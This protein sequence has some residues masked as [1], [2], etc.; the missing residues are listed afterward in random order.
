MKLIL[1]LVSPLTN[2]TLKT[3]NILSRWGHTLLVLTN[4]EVNKHLDNENQ[5]GFVQFQ[6]SQTLSVYKR[7]LLEHE[8]RKL[9]SVYFP[10]SSFWARCLIRLLVYEGLIRCSVGSTDCPSCV[11]AA[12]LMFGMTFPCLFKVGLMLLSICEQ[13]SLLNVGRCKLYVH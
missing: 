10:A 4:L 11:F 13:T 2:T 6:S 7:G 1:F 9:R 8:R 5:D 3:R 12:S